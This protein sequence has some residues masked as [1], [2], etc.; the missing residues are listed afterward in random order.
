MD[1]FSDSNVIVYTVDRAEPGKRAAARALL[2]EYLQQ[3][4]GIVSPQVLRGFYVAPARKLSTPLSE[5]AAGWAA[6]DI[7]AIL[8]LQLVKCI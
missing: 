2:S 7:G 1:P 5:D 6:G 4:S 3:G 8:G